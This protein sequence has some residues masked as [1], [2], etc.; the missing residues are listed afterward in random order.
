MLKQSYL[1]AFLFKAAIPTI[2]VFIRCDSPRSSWQIDHYELERYR[3]TANIVGLFR[4]SLDH[5]QDCRKYVSIILRYIMAIKAGEPHIPCW[6]ESFIFSV[7]YSPKFIKAFFFGEK[8][9]YCHQWLICG[10]SPCV[11]SVTKGVHQSRQRAM[12]SVLSSG[13]SSTAIDSLPKYKHG[14][15]ISELSIIQNEHRICRP[16]RQSNYSQAV[17]EDVKAKPGASPGWSIK[18]STHPLIDQISTTLSADDSMV[19][20][21]RNSRG[22]RNPA[23]M[24]PIQAQYQNDSEDDLLSIIASDI[25]ESDESKRSDLVYTSVSLEDLVDRLL[26]PIMSKSDT[27]FISTFLCLYRK[28]AAPS[29]LVAAIISRFRIV[30]E[31]Q[32]AHILRV[33]SQLRYLSVLAQWVSGYPGDFAHPLTQQITTQFLSEL[34]NTRIFAAACAEMST[35]L[36]VVVEDDDT[37][38][39]CSDSDKSKAHQTTSVRS[40]SSIPN[41][42]SSQILNSVKQDVSSGSDP[43]DLSKHCASRHSATL[44][45]GSSLGRSDSQSSTSCQTQ[46]DQ[47]ERARRQAR[48]LAPTPRICLAKAQWHRLMEIPEDDIAR[49]LTRID[50]VM[51]SSIRPRDLVRHVTLSVAE[52]GKCQGLENIDRM[53]NHFNHVAFWVA[54]LILLR[55]K[56]KHRARI[57]ERF[58]RIAWVSWST[59]RPP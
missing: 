21:E 48:F 26:S 2:L 42:T 56:P 9:F 33:T 30:S 29:D 8:T 28:F 57:L 14:R 46:L 19:D 23:T 39:A 45:I 17:A 18:L 5:S 12:T 38:W 24:V 4:F 55:D 49:E 44:S 59:L 50:W 31:S 16:L 7:V 37:E 47:A 52:K 10:T 54:N 11:V 43:G 34:G 20:P 53:I 32:E 22:L 51:Y 41:T 40:S 13:T 58:M 36:D 15:A 35:N 25:I 3:D 6:R 1:L 27:K